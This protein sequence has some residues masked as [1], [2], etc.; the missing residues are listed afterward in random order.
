MHLHR[1]MVKPVVIA[2]IRRAASAE[3]SHN[4]KKDYAELVPRVN[5][6]TRTAHR[7]KK[8]IHARCQA[9]PTKPGDKDFTGRA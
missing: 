9:A 8:L 2:A 3:Q 1:P 7:V 5:S 4:R 6:D